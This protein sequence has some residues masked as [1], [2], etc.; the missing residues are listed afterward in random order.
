MLAYIKIILLIIKYIFSY[1]WKINWT[2]IHNLLIT[3]DSTATNLFTYIFI[4]LFN[5]KNEK[6]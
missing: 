6:L 2:M 1:K 4:R 5:D 3:N